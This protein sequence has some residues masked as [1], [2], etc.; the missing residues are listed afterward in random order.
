MR[1]SGLFLFL[2]TLMFL[3]S[4][5]DDD[6][7]SEAVVSN[8][9]VIEIS[10]ATGEEGSS[11]YA[12]SA[13]FNLTLKGVESYAY[14][15]EKGETTDTPDGAVIFA[16]A[17][18]EG[19][20]GIIA[21]QDGTSTVTVYGLEGNTTYT[22][23]FAF[24]L[25]KEYVVKA[26]TI[27]TPA[28]SDVISLI[29]TSVDG[30]KFHIEVSED[31]Y[32]RYGIA[33]A[34]NYYTMKEQFFMTDYTFL[35]SGVI[36]KGPQTFDIKNGSVMDPNL[37]ADEWNVYNYFLPG[38]TYILLMGE[39][40]AEGNLLGEINPE[41]GGGGIMWSQAMPDFDNYVE[42]YTDEDF[43]YDGTFARMRFWTASPTIRENTTEVTTLKKTETSLTISVVPGEG[44]MSYGVGILSNA[45]YEYLLGWV[46][47]KG[48]M[49]EVFYNY[50]SRE[51]EPNEVGW[52][53][54]TVGETYKVFVISNYNEDLTEQSMYVM[55]VEMTESTNPDCQLV[56][57]P[58]SSTDPYSVTF[59]VK[60]PNK[61]CYGFRYL[62]NYMSE[63]ES[64]Y[65]DDETM[66]SMYGVDIKDAS[67]YNLVNSDEG[68]NLVF[69]SWENT[70]SK[71]LIAGYNVDEALSGIQESRNT[72]AMETG[73]PLQSD[74]FDK[75][76][77]T[78]TATYTYSKYKGGETTTASFPVVFTQNADE[79]PASISGI[80][81]EDY[82]NLLDY[83]MGRGYDEET[84][85]N[86]IEEYFNDYKESAGK[87]SEKYRNLNRIV[88]NGFEPLHKFMGTWDLFCNL[89]Y[90]S[91]TTDELFYDY[92]PKMFLQVV[93]NEAGEEEIGLVTYEYAIPPVS[94]GVTYYDYV[95]F[96]QNSEGEGIYKNATFPVTLSED[97]N[98]LTV[99]PVED[100]TISPYPLYPSIGYYM[101]ANYP[102]L[103]LWGVSGI[104]FTRGGEELATSNMSR[105]FNPNAVEPIPAHRSGNRFMK[106]Y[107]PTEK[108][109]VKFK[110]V[111]KEYQ[112]LET[113][114][115]ARIQKDLK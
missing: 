109:A 84:A 91:A 75:I 30:L 78:W 19:G 71:I 103:T 79:G 70:E 43:I 53:G 98:T 44:V 45:D 58:V 104:T 77:G 15:V 115:K 69:G 86:R 63:W 113:I 93:R 16:N 48:I 35:E 72:S 114:L 80:A 18:E 96:G 101:T 85:K 42:E 17:E 40:D 65:Y 26:Q 5:S 99:H 8:E 14:E 106:T 52:T 13:S 110:K 74:L 22:V 39:C 94:S 1:K 97:G 21:A 73:T 37:P 102:S 59:N 3:G 11:V 64:A 68:Y 10:T 34:D 89:S 20:S 83:W 33:L 50:T 27:T 108:T 55:D 6:P 56:V 4:C 47:E 46:G 112:S 100:N 57:T 66:F 54:L 12:T 9:P 25:E 28:Y 95:I 76:S 107:L 67:V 92:G 82:Q 7:Q 31:T 88:G 32:Y 41:F 23:F 61:D 51:T 24:K 49:S 111:T 60:A 62:M 38:G 105:S 29:S 90:E 2:T 81:S 36:A 87:Y